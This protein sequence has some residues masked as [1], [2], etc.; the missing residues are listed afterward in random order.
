M[1]LQKEVKSHPKQPSCKKRV[2]LQKGHCDKRCEIQ[3]GGQEMAV[4]VG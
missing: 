4:M 1:Q 2:R 3:D